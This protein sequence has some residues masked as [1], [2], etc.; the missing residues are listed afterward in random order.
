METRSKQADKIIQD[1]AF[2]SSLT[3]L[4]PIPL[5]DAVGLIGVQR[6]MIY[7]LSQLYGV[8]FTKNLGKTMVTTSF[9]GLTSSAVSPVVGKTLLKLVPGVGTAAGAMSMAALGSAS[10]Y[11]VGKV[12][13]QHLEE[14]GTLK[15]FNPEAS[16]EAYKEALKKGEEL[17]KKKA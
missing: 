6:F 15:D 16:R 1:F 2:R 3:G 7:R 8:P 14:G 10:T 12:F 13:Q 4:I 11:A 17:A 9:A 5:L